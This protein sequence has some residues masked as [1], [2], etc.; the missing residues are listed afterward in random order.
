M[1]EADRLFMADSYP[2][3]ARLRG[4]IVTRTSLP[5]NATR[6]RAGRLDARKGFEGRW[7][8]LQT[9][10]GAY[11]N[12]GQREI[13]DGDWPIRRDESGAGCA[14]E[15]RTASDR[16]LIAWRRK[17][18]YARSDREC[19]YASWLA[20]TLYRRWV[21]HAA[22]GSTCACFFRASQDKRSSQAA[23]RARIRRKLGRAIPQLAEYAHSRT[24]TSGGFGQFASSMPELSSVD[25]CWHDM[26]HATNHVPKNMR[27][28]PCI[29]TLMRERPQT[30]HVHA[31][32][33]DYSAPAA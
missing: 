8:T 13:P 32:F 31:S 5:P 12:D 26:Q 33:G 16:R 11:A 30:R 6:Q 20:D 15:R 17:D 7:R 24:S 9:R 14:Y 22:A 18:D 19:R 3:E 27:G 23:L 4:P 21:L 29:G 28:R 25:S 10:P 1:A 2:L